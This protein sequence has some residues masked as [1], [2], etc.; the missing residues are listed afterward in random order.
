MIIVMY[1]PP[2]HCSLCSSSDPT[3]RN[4]T[5]IRCTASWTPKCFFVD[6][7][8]YGHGGPTLRSLCHWFNDINL[9]CVCRHIVNH[10]PGTWRVTTHPWSCVPVA[11]GS[12]MSY[13]ISSIPHTFLLHVEY[14]P[15]FLTVHGVDVWPICTGPDMRAS[16]SLLLVIRSRLY[17]YCH[18]L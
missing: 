6:H 1:L 9:H 7:C 2:I 14:H 8:C 15:I 16:I 5:S 10:L 4:D 17:V 13:K 18:T 3:H 11:R 12:P